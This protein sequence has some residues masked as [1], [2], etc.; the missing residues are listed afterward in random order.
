MILKERNDYKPCLR[1]QQWSE[2]QTRNK[3]FRSLANVH[4]SLH[5]ARP[6]IG[7]ALFRNFM[8]RRAVLPS[9]DS[10]WPSLVASAHTVSAL[11]SNTELN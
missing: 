7:D 5:F 8:P 9:I 6:R 2:G 1:R 4:A 10:G 3:D 11:H